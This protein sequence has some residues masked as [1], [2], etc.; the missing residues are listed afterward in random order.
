MNIDADT[1]TVLMS[2]SAG[3]IARR[4]RLY[5]AARHSKQ[6]RKNIL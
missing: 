4:S 1:D 5:S 2:V 6:E 3:Y